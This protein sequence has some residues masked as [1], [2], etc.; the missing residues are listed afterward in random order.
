MPMNP[1]AEAV[2]SRSSGCVEALT[3]DFRHVFVAVSF[4]SLHR[5]PSPS[6]IVPQPHRPLYVQSPPHVWCRLQRFSPFVGSGAGVQSGSRVA[7]PAECAELHMQPRPPCFLNGRLGRGAHNAG[8]R[9]RIPPSRD[10]LPLHSFGSR[11]RCVRVAWRM[12]WS[13]RVLGEVAALRACQVV[14]RHAAHGPCENVCMFLCVAVYVCG[15][16]Q[17]THRPLCFI[18]SIVVGFCSRV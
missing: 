6:E 5:H 1:F 18:L 13:G 15:G 7:S 11:W 8:A 12:S 10:M 14:T 16:E 9:W 17:S 3:V 4:A 2:R